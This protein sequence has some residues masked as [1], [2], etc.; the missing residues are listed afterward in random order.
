MGN[1]DYQPITKD[2]NR[3]IDKIE[4]VENSQT[5][6]KKTV[7]NSK[8]YINFKAPNHCS[9][10][11]C[12]E[13][14]GENFKGSGKNQASFFCLKCGNG[15]NENYF[16]C[17]KCNSIFCS[18]CPYKNNTNLASCPS[19][20]ETSGGRFKGSGIN[21]ASFFCLKCGIGY[22]ENYFCCAKCNS[23]FCSQ[24]PYK[25]YTNLASCPSCGEL[26]GENFKGSDFKWENFY[27]LKCGKLDGI[28]NEEL[29]GHNC[30]YD[31]IKR[32]FFVCYICKSI[33]CYNCPYLKHEIFAK[34]PSC[35]ESV[36]EHFKGSCNI[37]YMQYSG[38]AK[39]TFVCLKCG[40][41]KF[42]SNYYKCDKCN[43]LFC[44]LCVF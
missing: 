7:E 14:A 1:C 33:F 8:I 34:C 9:C 43:C 21:K 2:D 25:N 40:R 38:I 23:I 39:H 18:Q 30:Y 20:G 36:G 35:G 6:K 32:N 37:R 44:P 13:I 5:D 27:C 3:Q 26:S 42:N 10:P 12:G 28:Y 11:S 29:I 17:A 24:C 41:S 22:N 4:T 19:C 15:Y 16:C 31:Y